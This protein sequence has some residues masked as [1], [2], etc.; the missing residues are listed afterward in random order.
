MIGFPKNERGFFMS[1][2]IIVEQ[3]ERKIYF[4]RGM[5]VM[6][7]RDLAE[8]YGVSTK[9]LN[10]QVRRNIKRFP[11]DFMFLLSM[12]EMKILRSQNATLE[13]GRYSK[14]QALTFTEQGIAMLSGVLNSERAIQTNIAIMRA[15]MKLREFLTTHKELAAQLK[16]L[17]R[18]VGVHD[19]QIAAIFEAIRRLMRE[20]EKPNKKIGFNVHA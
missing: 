15:F 8:L 16:E 18:K 11:N 12:E 6:L 5:K 20:E 10:E 9:R 1:K 13:M 7:D 3:I 2:I 14:H 4:M 19:G 17:E